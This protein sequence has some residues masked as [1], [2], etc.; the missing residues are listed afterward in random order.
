[1]SPLLYATIAEIL[2]AK[3]TH[4]SP[5][6][7]VKAY[8]D[9]TALVLWNFWEEAPILQRVFS[10]FELV[11]G[12]KLNLNKCVIMPLD[13]TPLE[14]FSEKRDLWIPAWKLMPVALSGKYLGYYIGPGKGTLSWNE[15]VRKY[16]NRCS[17][18]DGHGMGMYY[19][20][21]IYNTFAM[22]TLGFICQLENPPREALDAETKGIKVAVKGP[23]KWASGP[24]LW[25]LQLSYGQAQAPRSLLLMAQAA[26]L[27]V[28]SWD[29]ACKNG[30]YHAD[31]QTLRKAIA[32]T[33]N[34]YIKAK[35]SNW[36]GAAF[37]IT[38]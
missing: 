36:Y 26:Q 8:A 14:E 27:R 25:Q 7:Y 33:D 4:D 5:N 10:Q 3:I 15:P 16:N 13:G 23:P 30:Y 35:W 11:S 28:R 29:P 17:M 6:T 21:N 9:D 1:M 34:I 19:N 2:L 24:D 32:N 12:L 31:V 22:S 38:L 20:I 18:G 37:S